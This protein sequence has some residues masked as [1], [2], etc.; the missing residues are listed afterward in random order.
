M[1][2][3]KTSGIDDP[4]ERTVAGQAYLREYSVP[5][6]NEQH[7]VLMMRAMAQQI[8]AKPAEQLH[9]DEFG[10][11]YDPMLLSEVA[12]AAA[13]HGLCYLNE[14][15]P[16]WLND[17]FLP[18]GG[19]TEAVLRAAQLRDYEGITF[20]RKSLFVR[21]TCSPARKLSVDN[22]RDLYVACRSQRTGPHDF[23]TPDGTF[24]MSDDALADAVARLG[25]VWPHRM[26]ARDLVDS[27]ERV[28][29]LFH[30]FRGSAIGLHNSPF[31]ATTEPGERPA[32]SGLTRVQI[33]AGEAQILTLDHRTINLEMPDARALL[34]LLDGTRDRARLDQ[35]WRAAGYGIE[36]DLETALKRL[37]G[38]ALLVR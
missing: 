21:Q 6:E 28:L 14:A 20:F 11:V 22:I 17:G 12:A 37:A 10:S 29:A 3:L 4:V 32:V 24:S 34:A 5:K 19:D 2:L 27:E 8:G 35:E 23:I 18:D 38:E 26:L 31:P 25:E 30:L 9:H 1:A 36:I 13:E 33:A 15:E 7:P 16:G